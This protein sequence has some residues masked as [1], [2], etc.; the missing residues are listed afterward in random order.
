MS[1]RELEAA[2]ATCGAPV[3]AEASGRAVRCQACFETYLRGIDAAFLDNLARFG[4][5]GRQV[6]AETCL[7]A[8]VLANADDR[9]LLGMTVYEQF[10]L[11]A[12]DLIGLHR[13]LRRRR[14]Q[15]IAQ[16]VLEFQLDAAAARA[17]FAELASAGAGGMLRAV[18]LPHP[19]ALPP[20][21]GMGRKERREFERAL[22]AAVSD[23]DQLL[24]YQELGERALA[25]ASDHLRGATALA[26]RTQWLAGRAISPGQVA[27]IALDGDHGRLDVAALRI[28]E[29]RLE[30]V[31]NGIDIVVRL[32]RNLIHAF[33]TLHEPDEFRQGFDGPVRATGTG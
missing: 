30:Q 5:R 13:A 1:N 23:L 14:E 12:S 8:L 19:A 26:D 24:A 6:V 20:L 15:P 31:V 28:D 3:A 32:S 25:V 7:R 16:S 18:G 9:K 21:P 27:S 10:V 29:E 2:C 22:R 17:F 11:A 33:L 4:I